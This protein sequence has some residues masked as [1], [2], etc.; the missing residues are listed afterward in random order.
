MSIESSS[1]FSKKSAIEFKSSS[2]TV[3]ALL[4]NSNDL[5]DVVEKLQ[6]KLQQAPE[7]FKNSPVLLDIQALNTQGSNVDI[8][9]LIK[10]IRSNALIPVALRGGTFEQNQAAIKMGVPIQSV[11][12]ASHDQDKSPAPAQGV[13]VVSAIIPPVTAPPATETREEESSGAET[14]LITTP[15]RSGQRVYASGDLVILAQVSAGAE[16]MA[17]G[18]IHVY[19]SLRGRALAGVQGNPEARIFCFD[20]QAELISIAGNYKVNDDLDKSIQHKPVQ[21]YLQDHALIIKEL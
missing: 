14:T 13:E 16:I 12:T 6:Q 21:I 1:N 11:H 15:I 9:N 7:F 17:E 4:L 8:A 10:L 19:G 3:P 2:F 20:L 5:G 18:N